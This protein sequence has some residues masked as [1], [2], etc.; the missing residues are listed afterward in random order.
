[1]YVH[2]LCGSNSLSISVIPEYTARSMHSMHVCVYSNRKTVRA[3][4]TKTEGLQINNKVRWYILSR[5]MCRQDPNLLMSVCQA[6]KAL[7]ACGH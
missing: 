3:E 2:L 4:G 6:V 5:L 7:P 1:M